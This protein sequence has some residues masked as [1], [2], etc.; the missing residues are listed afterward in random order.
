MQLYRIIVII[1]LLYCLIRVN[2]SEN[3]SG[4]LKELGDDAT[5]PL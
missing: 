5:A 2:S 3:A 4:R 1:T